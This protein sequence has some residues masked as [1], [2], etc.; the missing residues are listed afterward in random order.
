[1]D[2]LLDLIKKHKRGDAVGI[3][4]VCSAHPFVIEAAIRQALKGNSVLLIEATSNQVDQF[5]GYTGM[6]PEDFKQFVC[7]I[8][9]TLNF[10]P[11]KLI[12]GGD[13]LGPNRWQKEDADSA[14]RKAEA[15]IAAYVAA[16]FKKIH[17][18]CSMSCAGDSV[19]LTDETVAARAARLAIIAEQTCIET[20]GH[21]DLVYVIGTEVPVPG[22]AHEA[23][24]ELAVTTPEAARQTI[25]AHWDAFAKVG[26]SHI[27]SRVIGLVVQPGVEFD[28]VGVIDYQPEKAA[29][30]SQMVEQYDHLIFEAHST[31]YQ[32][33]QAYQQLVRDHFAILKVG[34]A[35]TFALR[36]AL[37]SLACIEEELVAAR[38]C[39]G[40]RQVLEQAMHAQPEYWQG[41]YQGDAA[42][43]RLARSYSYSDRI[44]Y[45]WPDEKV[46]EGLDKLLSN[47]NEM[48]LPL[49]LLSQ[50]F[51]VQY[52]R[53]REGRLANQ[54]RELILDK[55]MQVTEV[56][57][58]ACLPQQNAA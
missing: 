5:G 9:Q 29:P 39:S 24:D 50:Y 28:H 35:L 22:G 52:Q 13:H 19:P 3:Y 42:I 14:M 25:H 46:G 43:Q 34:P 30:L 47:L 27:Q 37:F 31:D 49:P 40:L 26:L 15:Q 41:Y 54:A 36:E 18:D 53:I 12:L 55:I 32:T 44:R 8:A 2:I 6:T 23:L 57:A 45:Y 38:H 11:E 56:Y 16:G 20:F 48:P 21:S 7:S 17:L 1:M 51:P 58:T 10:P 33:E 4:S